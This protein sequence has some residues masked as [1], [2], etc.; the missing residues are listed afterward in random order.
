[1]NNI[2]SDIREWF[3]ASQSRLNDID[4]DDVKLEPLVQQTIYKTI[5]QMQSVSN[6]V[7]QPT[8]QTMLHTDDIAYKGFWVENTKELVLYVWVGNQSRAIIVPQDGWTI[9][10]DITIN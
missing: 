9:R 2:K 10:D 1:M 3:D 5:A 4:L 7:D 8:E 6:L